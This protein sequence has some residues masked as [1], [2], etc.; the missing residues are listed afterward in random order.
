MIGLFYLSAIMVAMGSLLDGYV[1]EMNNNNIII[2]HEEK[3][4]KRI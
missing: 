3:E 1:K 4:R 2:S